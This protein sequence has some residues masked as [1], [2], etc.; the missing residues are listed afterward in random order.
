MSVFLLN[1]QA[2]AFSRFFF[3]GRQN[4]LY[5]GFCYTYV[6]DHLLGFDIL[7]T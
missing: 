6:N 3:I 4:L 2:D 1:F 5:H 7:L